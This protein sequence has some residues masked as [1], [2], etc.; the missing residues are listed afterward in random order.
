MAVADLHEA[1]EGVSTGKAEQRLMIALAYKNGVSVEIL[2]E[3]YDPGVD[4]VLLA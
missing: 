4:S 1:L 3:R 2:S